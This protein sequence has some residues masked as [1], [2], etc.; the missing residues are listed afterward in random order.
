MRQRQQTAQR[1]RDIAER[2]GNARLLRVADDMDQRAVE[3]YEQR[4]EQLESFGDQLELP[5]ESD[6][7]DA[8]FSVQECL[9]T[10]LRSSCL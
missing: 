7:P 1:F 3:H 10:P 9:R 8:E 4:L 5:D 2:N 6:L